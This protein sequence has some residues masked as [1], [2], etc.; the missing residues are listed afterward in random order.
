MRPSIQ[1]LA[2]IC[3]ILF[4]QISF[5]QTPVLSY[6]P[7]ISSGLSL[8]VEFIHAG[9]GSNRMFIV[10]QDGLIKVYNGT[11]VLATPFLNL[12]TVT[13]ASGEQGLLSMAFHPNYSVNGYFFVYYNNSSGDITIARYQ[14]SA[15]N[16]NVANPLSGVVLMTIPKPFTNHNGG[17]LAFGPDG[18]LYFGTGDGGS[19]GD[20][21]NNA[22]NGNSLLGKMI[23][24]DVNNFATPP[25]YTIPADNPYVGDATVL[26]VVWALG[27]RN[28][29]RWSFDRL[30]GDMWIGEVGQGA[31]EEINFRDSGSTGGINYGW[32]CYEGFAAFNTAGCAAQNTYISPIF[33]YPHNGLTGGFSV[34]GGYVYRGSEFSSLYGYYICADYVSGNTWLI[35]PAGAGLW[36]TTLQPGLPGSVSA[37]GEAENGTLYAVARNTGIIH[38]INVAGVLPVRLLSFTGQHNVLYNELKWVTTGEQ[39]I[40]SFRV[41][42]SETGTAFQP[43]GNVLPLNNNNSNEYRFT[44]PAA[45][46]KMYYRLETI[47]V[48]GTIHYSPVIVLGNLKETKAVKCFVANNTLSVISSNP[49]QTV[50]LFSA[51]GKKIWTM[52]ATNRQGYFSM[53][54]PALPAGIYTAVVQTEDGVY[55]S[56]VFISGR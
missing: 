48:N 30:T 6:T 54:I 12:T 36:N 46:T 47:D 44:H 34:T 13:N 16:A 26:D 21:F 38:K 35:T 25:Y 42:F 28:P 5:A 50:S 56:R 45:T 19:G 11:S 15:G 7:T 33:D 4:G 9:D 43:A 40:R 49:V 20:P 39:D 2:L 17:H 53:N 1:T 32:R 3:F 27:V 8:P 18:Y 51:G 24:I 29:W 37:F 23:R 55:G 52:N 14:V 10:E 31:R 41:T 22:Q